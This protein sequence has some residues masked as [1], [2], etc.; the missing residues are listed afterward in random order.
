LTKSPKPSPF[1]SPRAGLARPLAQPRARRARHVPRSF[2]AAGKHRLGAQREVRHA[3][4][5]DVADHGVIAA[6]YVEE[7]TQHAPVRGVEDPHGIAGVAGD[8]LEARIA[9]E[10][11]HRQR[12]A[13]LVDRQYERRVAEAQ[14]VDAIAPATND[15]GYAVAIEVADRDH[16]AVEAIDQW[17]RLQHAAVAAAQ[18]PQF[19]AERHNRR[20][21]RATVAVAIAD[22]RRQHVGRRRLPQQGERRTRVG[23]QQTVPAD[24][25]VGA[26]VEVQVGATEHQAREARGSRVVQEALRT[27]RARN[28]VDASIADVRGLDQEVGGAVAIEVAGVR[29]L[30]A[31]QGVRNRTVA[32]QQDLLAGQKREAPRGE[33]A[34][35]AMAHLRMVVAFP[36]V[37]AGERVS[38]LFRLHTTACSRRG[39]FAHSPRWQ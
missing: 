28:D 3:V 34:G 31:G 36:R 29:D 15:L 9:R 24:D 13:A 5:V 1:T 10:V 7:R 4:G 20:K 32:R 21:V 19:R 37:V 27:V 18:H 30:V 8:D 26:A 11:R 33:H 25:D 22:R 16:H 14:H 23:A 2:D 38:P 6:R 17:P 35:E 12:Q 39:E